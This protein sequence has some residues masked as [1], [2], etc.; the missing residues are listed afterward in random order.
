MVEFN[1]GNLLKMPQILKIPELGLAFVTMMVLR[2]S[3]ATGGD[4]RDD[5]TFVGFVVY[6]FFFIVL[7]QLIGILLGDRSPIQDAVYA[8]TGAIFYVAAGGAF[9]DAANNDAG[10]GLGAMCIITGAVFLVDTAF[11]LISLKKDL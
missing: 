6:S 1:L 11:A 7:V 2:C 9:L 4:S 10:N 5:S 3:N 8:L